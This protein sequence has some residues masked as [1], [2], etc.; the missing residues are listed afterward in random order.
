VLRREVADTLAQNKVIL[1]VL[2]GGALM[3]DSKDLPD[4]ITPLTA[5]NALAVRDTNWNHDVGRLLDRLRWKAA[6]M[7]LR[8]VEGLVIGSPKG[9]ARLSSCALA[10]QR[11]AAR[12]QRLAG[13]G[14]RLSDRRRGAK[15]GVWSAYPCVGA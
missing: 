3:P 10:Q 12:S 11:P 13:R 8:E 1:P 4:D 7:Y 6:Q 14:H 2:V 15:K 9:V 5:L